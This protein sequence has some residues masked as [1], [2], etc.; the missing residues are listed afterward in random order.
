VI[1]LD[2]A[3]RAIAAL[4]SPGGS[5]ILAYNAKTLV[6]LLAWRLPLQEAID[7]PNVIARGDETFGEAPKLAPAVLEAIA[8]RGIVV[9]PGRGEE[10]GLHGL[11]IAADGTVTGAADPR[12]E[13]VWK[14]L[15]PMNRP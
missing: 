11:V 12:R 5:S 1:V 14:M 6:G 10:S 7:L 9:K 8:A 3:G 4:G 2:Q 15:V 13:G